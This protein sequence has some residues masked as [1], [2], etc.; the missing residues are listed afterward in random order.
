GSTTITATVAAG[1]PANPGY[2]TTV[3]DLTGTSFD[4]RTTAQHVSTLQT[5]PRAVLDLEWPRRVG[6]E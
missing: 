6:H 1:T 3:R 2:A 5:N 4:A